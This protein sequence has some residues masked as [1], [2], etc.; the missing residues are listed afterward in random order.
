MEEKGDVTIVR[1]CYKNGV[2]DDAGRETVRVTSRF[3][4]VRSVDRQGWVDAAEQAQKLFPPRKFAVNRG[5]ALRSGSLK[6]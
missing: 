3:T 2:A 1:T 4:L 6:L 5:A